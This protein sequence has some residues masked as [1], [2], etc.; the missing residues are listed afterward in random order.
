MDDQDRVADLLIR[1][2]EHFEDGKDIS[3]EELCQEHPELTSALKASIHAVKKMAWLKTPPAANSPKPPPS[4][5]GETVL[6]FQEP[7]AGR[8]RMEKRIAGGGFGEVWR[9]F[10]LELQ[11]PVAIKVP[12][13]RHRRTANEEP[14]Q[15]EARKVAQLRHPGIVQVHDVGRSNGMYFIVSDLIEGQDLAALLCRNKPTVHEAVRIVAEAARHLHY[16]HQQGFI[17]RDIK[18]ANI[19]VD[20]H[21][22][23][24]LTDF[25]IAATVE[26][27]R[28]RGDDGCG[29][30]AYM[31]PE[32]LHGDS[33]RIDARTD[34]YGLGVVLYELLT[35]QHPFE[36]VNPSAL[37]EFILQQE[38]RNPRSINPRIPR[39]IERICMK[40][41]SK[42]PV[43]RYASADALAESLTHALRNRWPKYGRLTVQILAVVLALIGFIGIESKFREAKDSLLELKMLVKQQPTQSNDQ[44]ASKIFLP[45][46]RPSVTSQSKGE[47]NGPIASD[48]SAASTENKF[49]VN[50]ELYLSTNQQ[51]EQMA[52][53]SSKTRRIDKSAQDIELVGTPPELILAL[54]KIRDKLVGKVLTNLPEEL[55]DIS[56]VLIKAKLLFVENGSG[57]LKVIN[58][59]VKPAV[60]DGN[61]AGSV[62]PAVLENRDE[63][64]R[65]AKGIPDGSIN[66]ENRNGN[67][68][69]RANVARS[70]PPLPSTPNVI[71]LDGRSPRPKP[72][73][74]R[75][76]FRFDTLRSR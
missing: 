54:L 73:I 11:R 64:K 1:W 75:R 56:V 65:S 59:S 70:M 6:S 32:Q 27:L 61:E 3:V 20:R 16:A 48:T 31:S 8:Y 44:A 63:V 47:T 74:F 9:G 29:T 72:I 36:A 60:I 53:E 5:T 26:Q 55:Q 58:P 43:N 28:L 71:V 41:L 10:D 76:V 52:A 12:T 22:R 50:V 68:E 66:S 25:G 13:T 34:I 17:H 18:P 24:Y 46:D 33:T 69:E 40:C 45:E 38:P 49:D 7:L 21:D 37:H 57:I 4:C 23:V 39:E 67:R 30:L 19:L 42:S 51:S 14:F 15:T 62:K 2:Q 35:R